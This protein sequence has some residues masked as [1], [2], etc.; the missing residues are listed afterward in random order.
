MTPEDLKKM[1]PRPPAPDLQAEAATD[2]ME[3]LLAEIDGLVADMAARQKR[4][5]AIPDGWEMVPLER[6]PAKE[7]ITL[8]LDRDV[9]DYFRETGQGW[10]TRL[11]AVL[12][13][14][15]HHRTGTE[16]E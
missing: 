14:F 15:M 7:K 2:H 8:R 6:R 10:Q 9:L 12:R 13:L 16:D 11:N 3:K 4:R 1:L 5:T